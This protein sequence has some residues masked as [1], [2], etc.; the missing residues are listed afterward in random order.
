MIVAFGT[1]TP[2]SIT[3]VATST[4]SSPSLNW[5]ITS[6]R[7]AGLQLPVQQP[8]AVARELGAAQ[9][10]GLGLGGAREPRL[11]LLDQRA[12]D[13]RL[14]ARVEMHAQ[15]R[16]RRRRA[17]GADPARH[18]R[19]AVGGRLRDLAHREVAV[20]RQRERARDRRR[21]HVQHVRRAT[22]RERL[23]AARRRSGA[24]RRRR[25]RRDRRT[26]RPR[27]ISA[28]VPTTIARAVRELARIF[29][30]PTAPV[31]SSAAHAEL[32]RRAARASGS[33]AR[34]ASRSAPSARPGGRFSTARS[35]A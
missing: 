11:R 34:R 32:A 20:D 4:S 23:A 24:A 12:D 3:V 1:S 17:L 26:R 8:D 7:S 21:R 9:A 31:S 19:L 13:V 30:G 5:R 35:S 22:L 27:W 14:P 25:R 2:T 6:R 15:P 16:V 29:F 18:D 28:C 33:A 10:L